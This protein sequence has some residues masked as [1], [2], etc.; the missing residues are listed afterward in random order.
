MAVVSTDRPGK[1]LFDILLFGAPV[2][3][4]AQAAAG[5]RDWPETNATFSR[6]WRRA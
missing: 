4:E 1:L 6:V 3:D 2:P 5:G